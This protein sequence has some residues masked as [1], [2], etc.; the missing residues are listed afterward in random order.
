MGTSADCFRSKPGF[1][2]ISTKL[3]LLCHSRNLIMYIRGR[4]SESKKGKYVLEGVGG[5]EQKL[6]KAELCNYSNGIRSQ[7]KGMEAQQQPHGGKEGGGPGERGRLVCVCVCA[8]SCMS[9][10]AGRV[11]KKIRAGVKKDDLASIIPNH[12]SYNLLLCIT[13]RYNT[14]HL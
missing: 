10:C 1:K 13:E 2:K 8:C 6:K 11:M 4:R 7:T 9:S 5:R 3:K 14:L 12:L